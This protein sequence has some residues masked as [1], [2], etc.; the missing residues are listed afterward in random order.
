MNSLHFFKDDTLVTFS[1]LYPDVYLKALQLAFLPTIPITNHLYQLASFFRDLTCSGFEYTSDCHSLNTKK[2]LLVF[3][4]APNAKTLQTLRYSTYDTSAI[5]LFERPTSQP[6][7]LYTML[8]NARYIL[9]SYTLP[10]TYAHHPYHYRCASAFLYKE[11]PLFSSASET[12]TYQPAFN[13][14]LINSNLYG[15]NSN[16]Y[17]L[18]RELINTCTALQPQTFL[19]YGRGWQFN[20]ISNPINSLLFFK[21]EFRSR[22]YN[23]PPIDLSSYRGS[24]TDKTVL[25]NCLTNFSI[26][27]FLDFDGYHTEKAYEPLIYGCYPIYLANRSFNIFAD[28]LLPN[29]ADPVLLLSRALKVCS[30]GPQAVRNMALRAR[31]CINEYISFNT[32]TALQQLMRIIHSP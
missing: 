26:E 3:L 17:R 22:L 6:S 8:D 29:E 2:K 5:I 24:C 15:N 30:S 4:D 28:N 13:L 14:S 10:G 27:N 21:N 23:F 20:P 25:L 7:T 12:F 19:F 32:N 1:G 9:S 16:T 31:S 11:I 18:R